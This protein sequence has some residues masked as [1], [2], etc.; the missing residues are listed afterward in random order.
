MTLC[1]LSASSQMGV[2]LGAAPVGMPAGLGTAPAVGGGLGDLFDLG[3]GVGMATAAYVPPKAVSLLVSVCERET[4]VSS[5]ITN[6]LP[7]V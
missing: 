6:L 5:V 1:V 7:Q 2:G 4:F 3:G